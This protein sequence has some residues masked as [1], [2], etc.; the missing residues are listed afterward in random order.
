M[1]ATAAIASGTKSIAKP[2]DERNVLLLERVEDIPVPD[3]ESVLDEKLTKDDRGEATGQKPGLRVSIAVSKSLMRIARTGRTDDDGR[4]SRDFFTQPLQRLAPSR[5][6]TGRTQLQPLADSECRRPSR[7]TRHKPGSVVSSLMSGLTSPCNPGPSACACRPSAASMPCAGAA[8]GLH[9]RAPLFTVS[10]DRKFD[11]L[12]N[13]RGVRQRIGLEDDVAL[14]VA[15]NEL[16][17][18]TDPARSCERSP[19]RSC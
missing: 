9:G 3:V 12:G 8:A 10:E 6:G 11:V 4:A 1:K 7:M 19:G 2:A 13:A 14:L 16:R 5:G 18:A 15:Q 17:S